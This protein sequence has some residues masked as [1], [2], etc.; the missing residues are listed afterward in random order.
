[1]SEEQHHMMSP[2]DLPGEPLDEGGGA[3][4]W[5]TLAIMVATAV[6]MA[7]NA[8][9]LNGWAVEL[10]PGPVASRLAAATGW[11]DAITQRNLGAPRAWLHAQW[12]RA[13]AARFGHERP[14]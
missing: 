14:E 10:P 9:T 3:W 1:M 6:L 5:T 7:A 4:R 13:Q 11:W 12:E 2:V 8:T